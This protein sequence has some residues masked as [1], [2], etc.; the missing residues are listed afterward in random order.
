MVDGDYGENGADAA[1]HVVMVSLPASECV[2]FP[3][4]SLEE[5]PAHSALESRN[6]A[7]MSLAV[8]NVK[9]NT[10]HMF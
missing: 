4:P 5:N 6:P 3:Y 2:T 9:I 7:T 1:C 8:R 10:L